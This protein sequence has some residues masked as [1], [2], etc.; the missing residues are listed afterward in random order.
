MHHQQQTC[1]VVAG[2]QGWWQ[3]ALGQVQGGHIQISP[4]RTM[5]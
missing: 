2:G 3:K 5:V 4:D 1:K